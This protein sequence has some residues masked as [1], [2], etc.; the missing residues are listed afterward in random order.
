M[1]KFNGQDFG[2]WKIQIEYYI[3]QKKLHG[4]LSEREPEEM[5]QEDWEL[6][7]QQALG[8]VILSLANNI[9]DNIVLMV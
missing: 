9:A 4:P 7:Y 5:K 8:V 1:H 2:F 3:Y 6:L